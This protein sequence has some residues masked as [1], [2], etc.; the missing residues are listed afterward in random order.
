MYVSGK[1]TA[2]SGVKAA[3]SSI[4]LQITILIHNVAKGEVN[5]GRC[6][7]YTIYPLLTV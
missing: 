6:L 2:P 1:Q 3:L 4:V 5:Y 7:H